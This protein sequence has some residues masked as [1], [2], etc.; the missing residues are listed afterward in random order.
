MESVE[1]HI[2]TS[3]SKRGRGTVFFS[4]T[5]AGFEAPKP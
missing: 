4:D 1:K 5:F 3:L 2:I